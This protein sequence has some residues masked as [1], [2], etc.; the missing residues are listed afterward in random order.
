[1]RYL[2]Y[3][4]MITSVVLVM[5][6][7]SSNFVSA[8]IKDNLVNKEVVVIVSCPKNPTFI[9]GSLAGWISGIVGGVL[10]A[11]AE[12]WWEAVVRGSVG[13]FLIGCINEVVIR[14]KEKELNEIIGRKNWDIGELMRTTVYGDLQKSQKSF[15]LVPEKAPEVDT[16]IEL[17]IIN[18][19]LTAEGNILNRKVRRFIDAK[20]KIVDIKTQKILWQKSIRSYKAK[21]EADEYKKF[22]A[23]NGKLLKSEL[24]EG[25]KDISRKLVTE[26]TGE[27]PK[28]KEVPLGGTISEETKERGGSLPELVKHHFGR[29]RSWAV[30][31]GINSYSR[32]S[33]FRPLTYAV[34]D[35]M[36]VQ[37]YLVKNLDFAKERVISIYNQ[38]ATKKR[39]EALL[40]DENG[41]PGKL[42]KGDRLLVFF[43]GHGETRKTREGMDCGYLVPV[44]GNKKELESTCI[45]MDDLV[46]WSELI[47]AQQILFIIDA[48]YSGIAGIIHR[49]GEMPKET[50][51]QVEIFIKSGGRQ[52]MTAGSSK[53]T[54]VESKK[55]GGSVYVY[56]LLRG[57]KGDADYNKDE[58]ISVRELQVYL[59]DKVPKEAN[60]TPQLYYLGRGEGQFVFYR[61]GGW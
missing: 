40:G 51:K 42:T 19:G 1:M 53:E 25:V 55:W 11:S 56:Y 57:L 34:A 16:I 39:I 49:K 24:S 52:I 37:D 45:S 36:A 30:V 46:R 3:R 48:C 6:L 12:N 61:E 9:E 59:D 27:P 44:D 58:V 38:E 47:P 50:R 35:A 10:G 8:S 28:S 17:D 5:C 41:L 14:K 29:S 2:R 60:Q 23:E 15:S 32:N 7:F 43:A 20:V 54:V 4:M 22:I 18:Y 13:G 31:I 33:G 26:L 21:E